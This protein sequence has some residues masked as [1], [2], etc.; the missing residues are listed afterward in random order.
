[1][2]MKF[3]LTDVHLEILG[4]FLHVLYCLIKVSSLF[5]TVCMFSR[6]LN[7]K[8]MHYFV[9]PCMCLYVCV[10]V[11]V[12][13]CACVFPCVCPCVCVCV[14]LCVSLCMCVCPY[15]C[16]PVCVSAVLHAEGGHGSESCG[17]RQAPR[18]PHQGGRGECICASE[19]T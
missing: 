18:C 3:D 5:L 13:P 10:P 17:A 15:V 9:C 1:M 14:S 12:C 6:K 2:K 7:I 8:Y 4:R 16:V 11:C 19:L